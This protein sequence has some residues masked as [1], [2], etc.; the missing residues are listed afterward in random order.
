MQKQL[1]ISLMIF[2]LFACGEPKKIKVDPELEKIALP[3]TENG[4]TAEINQQLTFAVSYLNNILTYL[5]VKV[6]V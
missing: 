3:N 1:V 2:S 6:K 4:H 5:K